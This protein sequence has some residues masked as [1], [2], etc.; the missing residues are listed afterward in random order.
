MAESLILVNEAIY[1]LILVDNPDELSIRDADYNL[2]LCEEGTIFNKQE[3]EHIMHALT[4]HNHFKL[5]DGT[6]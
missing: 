1:P 3:L 6:R 4:L 2:V 5:L